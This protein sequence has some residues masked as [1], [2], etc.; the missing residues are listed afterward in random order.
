MSGKRYTAEFEAEA[1]K[2]ALSPGRLTR[3]VAQRPGDCHD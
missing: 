3:E 1:I 2:Q